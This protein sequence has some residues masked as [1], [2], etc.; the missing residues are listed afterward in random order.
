MSQMEH[1]LK[2]F[3]GS[4]NKLVDGMKQD[5]DNHLKELQKSSDP[6]DAERFA[7]AMNDNDVLTKA[8][9]AVAEVLNSAKSIISF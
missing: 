6:K 3:M 2:D 1:N 5:A 8:N 4:L 9:D 7:K